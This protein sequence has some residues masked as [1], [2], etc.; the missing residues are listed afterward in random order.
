MTELYNE[1]LEFFF[2]NLYTYQ[3]LYS[4]LLEIVLDNGIVEN[5]VMFMSWLPFFEDVVHENE[6]YVKF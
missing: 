5:L 6:I 2:H 3:T 1:N 4:Y